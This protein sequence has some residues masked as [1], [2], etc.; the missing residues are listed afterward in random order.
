MCDL[1]INF[2]AFFETGPPT[3]ILKPDIPKFT[4]V[5]VN[6]AYLEATDAKQ[7]DLVAAGFLD[8]FPENPLDPITKNVQSLRNSLIEAVLTKKKHVLPSQKYDIPVW[9]T[10]QFDVRYWK[11]TNSPILNE[12]GEVEYIVHVTLDITG[13]VETAQKERFAFEVAEA[14]RKATMQIEERLRLA[15]D[16]A[17]LGTWYIDAATRKFVPSSRLKEMFGYHPDEEM[18][19]EGTITQVPEEYR[20]RIV[21]AIEDAITKNQ[22]YDIEYPVIGY[23]DKKLRWV[24]ATGKLFTAQENQP[25]NFSGTMVDITERKQDEQRKNDFIAMVS[26]ELKTPL[27]ISN[28]YS[29]LLLVKAKKSNDTFSVNTLEK[30]HKQLGKMTKMI[31]GF[32]DA[33]RVAAGK[34]HIEC[35]RFDMAVLIK[36]VEEE[37]ISDADS[38]RVVFK[39][40]ETTWVNVDKE[41]IEHV[42]NNFL[43][44]A[45]KY[46]PPGSPIQVTCV[47]NNGYAEVSVK[48]EGMGIK[49][50][51]ISRLFDRFYRVENN[52]I[53]SVT[54]FGIGLY[55]CKEIIERHE[56]K[57]W[58]ES[59][60]GKGSTFYFSLPLY[61]G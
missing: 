33:S 45:I 53:Q 14:Q 35:K 1:H 15:I 46:S 34:I 39:P 7:E 31:E 13:A 32:L 24:K 22:N 43:T 61:K 18:T 58:V 60:F 59:E 41:K 51:D 12:A 37:M 23:H 44:N 36:E 8:A 17:S 38:K 57:I 3:V 16:S 2:A 56:G 21:Q 40:V 26:H 42:I 54:G 10:N 29:Q 11:A 49:Q 20:N 25:A 6:Q 5:A 30:V 55:I 47:T 9:G 48:D 50:N 19:F 4:I 27:T 28:G 52:Q